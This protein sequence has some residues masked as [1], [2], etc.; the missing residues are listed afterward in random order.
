MTHGSCISDSN[1]CT[2]EMVWDTLKNACVSTS[3][4]AT[5]S[6]SHN[7]TVPDGARA[8]TSSSTMYS[9]PQ[10][11]GT[12][13]A[14]TSAITGTMYIATQKGDVQN[15][16][17]VFGNVV[18]KIKTSVSSDDVRIIIAGENNKRIFDTSNGLKRFEIPTGW[19]LEWNTYSMQNGTYHI[20]AEVAASGDVRTIATASVVVANPTSL[21]TAPKNE[22][23]PTTNT[24]PRQSEPLVEMVDYRTC[25]TPEQ[26]LQICAV[27]DA[28]LEICKKFRTEVFVTQDPVRSITQTVQEDKLAQVLQTTMSP[29]GMRTIDDVHAYCSN[30]KNDAECANF[31]IEKKLL[32]ETVII[33]KKKVVEAQRDEIQ[34]VI[35]ERTGVRMYEDTDTDGISDY[36]ELNIYRTNPNDSD[37]DKDGVKD[38]DELLAGTNPAVSDR[39]ESTTNKPATTA[40]PTASSSV[41]KPVEQ[42]P[43]VSTTTVSST[44]IAVVGKVM[45]ENPKIVGGEETELLVAEEVQPVEK[46]TNENGEETIKKMEFKGKA[47]PNSFVTVYVFS[48]PIVVTVKTDA[49][50]NWSYVLDKELEDGEHE[51]YVAMTDGGGKIVAKSKPLPFV[52]EASAVTTDVLPLLAASEEVEQS[53]VDRTYLYLIGLLVVVIMGGALILV[54]TRRASLQKDTQPSDSV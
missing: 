18:I 50:G 35:V 52:K 12:Q 5:T 41:Y 19:L 48:T 54:A 40:T 39:I 25:E 27:S 1:Y 10:K 11:Q 3:S 32:D 36:D 15:G 28:N 23:I 38:G 2:T 17:T 29:G 16:G 44:T 4:T 42:L 6:T 47:L 13:A 43:I 49:N 31:L 33:E 45:Y 51:V 22:T 9:L 20:V 7:V 26:C 53:I 14:T 46:G 30:P 34:R 21:T 24:E 37:T 8:S